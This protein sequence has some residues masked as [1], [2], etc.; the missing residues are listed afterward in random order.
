MIN[1]WLLF[2]P[3]LWLMLLCV[4]TQEWR[5]I[6]VASWHRQRYPTITVKEIEELDG[7][8]ANGQFEA[9]ARL[10]DKL[11]AEWEAQKKAKVRAS[12]DRQEKIEKPKA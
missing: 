10:R 5:G 1:W 7:Y 4:D 8:I 12:V 3:H 2:R 9:A 11:D 6:F